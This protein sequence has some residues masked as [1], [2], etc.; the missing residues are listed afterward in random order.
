M[1][2]NK[3]IVSQNSEPV[4]DV[5]AETWVDIFRTVLADARAIPRPVCV[6][7]YEFVWSCKMGNAYKKVAL[8][9]KCYL[10]FWSVINLQLR[11]CGLI[12]MSG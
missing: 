5:C 9:E 2:H 8:Q 12:E 11:S 7:A 4:D 3:A 6:V 1:S 10:G